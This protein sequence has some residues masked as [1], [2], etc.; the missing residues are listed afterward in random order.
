VSLF[1]FR[2]I[3][4]L[5]CVSVFNLWALHRETHFYS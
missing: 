5:D 4:N 1:V 2:P 3:A